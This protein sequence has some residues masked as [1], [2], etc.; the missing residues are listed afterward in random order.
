MQ[1]LTEEQK[2]E[3]TYEIENFIHHPGIYYEKIGRLHH[4][5]SN[6]KLVIK[7]NITSLTNRLSQLQHYIQKTENQCKLLAFA[8]RETCQ[9]FN[10]IIAKGYQRTNR[11]IT[12]ISSTYKVPKLQKR[13]LIDGIGSVA[14]SLFGTMDAND[15]KL[16]NEQLTI[17][18]NSQQLTQHA[19]KNQIKIIN[20]TIAHIDDTEKT[21]Q[22]NEYIL[23]NATKKLRTQLLD[24][25]RRTSIDEHFIVINAI[26]AD[27]NRD[28]EDVL[29]YLVSIE[30]G[31]L[32]PRLTPV[33]QIIEY[34]KDAISQLPEGLY[35][36]F[37][38]KYEEWSTIK[39]SATIS[40]YSDNVNIYTILIFPLISLPKYEIL[41]VIPIP[42]PN[43]DNIFTSIKVNNPLIAV[44]TERHTYIVPTLT[45][46]QQCI[47]INTEYLCMRNYPTYRINTNSICEIELY[48]ENKQS[49]KNCNIQYIA[50]NNTIWIALNNPN[51]WIY[52]APNKLTATIDC[53]D[54]GIIKR[55]IE[56]T[57]KI[58]LKN[59]CKIIAENTI[60]KSQKMSHEAKIDSYLPQYNISLLSNKINSENDKS[61]ILEVKIKKITQNSSELENLENDL[62]KIN[63]DLNKDQ[64]VNF[65]S[66][67]F[68]YPMA[69]SGATMLI[70][71]IIVIGVIIIIVRKRKRSKPTKRVT[72][73]VE[74]ENEFHVPRSVLKRYNSTRF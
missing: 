48:L 32:H 39:K 17:L 33:D 3:S 62:N 45:D 68:I 72:I 12:R 28:A 70:I 2:I 7:I 66:H 40:A 64:S 53:K 10:A 51:T 23:A 49:Y 22:N 47:K 60:L 61:K 8:D 31:I 57:G 59:N 34:L 50:S 16:I 26:L 71:L 55:K 37:R 54:H 25:E 52:S 69:T 11:L 4:V 74:A 65:Q 21:I 73:D 36:P 41:N 6:W 58:I 19:I 5:E 44:D 30:K 15:E 43:H 20:A 46:I 14:K 13:G 63:T 27:L 1:S 42:I 29:E 24:N 18:H 38:V 56:N 35:F 67:Y 9:N